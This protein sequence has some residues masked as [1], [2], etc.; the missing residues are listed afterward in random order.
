MSF[1]GASLGSPPPGETPGPPWNSTWVSPTLHELLGLCAQGERCGMGHIP[2]GSGGPE[3]G[4]GLPAQLRDLHCDSRSQLGTLLSLLCPRQHLTAPELHTGV[5]V[6]SRAWGPP[7]SSS[8]DQQ[9]LG[10]Q[11]M[12]PRDS[13]G[14]RGEAPLLPP[15]TPTSIACRGIS[16]GY[17]CW[18]GF[19][20]GTPSPAAPQA[21]GSDP[22]PQN[23]LI[24]GILSYFPE[25]FELETP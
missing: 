11:D 9:L 12:V 6:S 24:N 22:G 21:L 18:E 5:H 4:Q 14:H 10:A 19:F 8:R 7:G 13:M 17:W 1:V 23:S 16:W 15:P 2:I 25:W 20:R 3:P